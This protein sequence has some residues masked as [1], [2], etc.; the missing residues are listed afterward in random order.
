MKQFY[1]TCEIAKFC[2]V[3]R[4]TVKNWLEKN[5]LPHFRTSGGHRRV[6]RSELI[7]YLE[8]KGYPLEEFFKYEDEFASKKKRLFCWEYFSKH[9]TG[10]HSNKCEECV[11]YKSRA[12]NCYVV[13]TDFGLNREMCNK[14]SCAECEYYKKYANK[15]AASARG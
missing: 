7:E 1:T 11:A 8:T 13:I 2:G 3:S 14:E 15:E 10:E 5:A 6:K 4:I 9:F 12:L